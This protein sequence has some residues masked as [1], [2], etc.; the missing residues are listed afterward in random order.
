MSITYGETRTLK[1]GG[2]DGERKDE[3]PCTSSSFV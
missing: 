2:W 3:S 1:G